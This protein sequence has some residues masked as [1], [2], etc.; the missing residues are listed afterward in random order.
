NKLEVYQKAVNLAD[1]ITALTE[2]F[3]K[4]IIQP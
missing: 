1:K 2:K 4:R 3:P